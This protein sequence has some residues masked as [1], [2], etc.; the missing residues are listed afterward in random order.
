MLP[1]HYSPVCQALPDLTA[2]AARLDDITYITFAKSQVRNGKSLFYAAGEV[3]T[4]KSVAGMFSTAC[5][6]ATRDASH[7]RNV[8]RCTTFYI[9]KRQ[10]VAN[11]FPHFPSIFSCRGCGTESG[12]F[13]VS[14]SVKWQGHGER[15]FKYPCS[16]L[17]V[18]VCPCLRVVFIV[19]WRLP[20]GGGGR[21]LWGL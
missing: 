13:T 21:R 7:G 4:E 10:A 16:P 6:F 17:R 5:L 19:G 12:S 20:N 11:I 2:V 18:S 15:F 9:A 3:K 14:H 8:S 1:L